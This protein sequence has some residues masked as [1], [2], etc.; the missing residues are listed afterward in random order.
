[1]SANKNIFISYIQRH[2]VLYNWWILLRNLTNHFDSII[3]Y[4]VLVNKMGLVLDKP[5]SQELNQVLWLALQNRVKKAHGSLDIGVFTTANVDKEMDLILLPFPDVI[6]SIQYFFIVRSTT[7]GAEQEIKAIDM[8]LHRFILFFSKI[9]KKNEGNRSPIYQLSQREKTCLF[10]V[11]QG[12]SSWETSKIVGIT[13]RT[14]NLHITN[15]IRKTQSVNRQQAIT[16][17]LILNE[18]I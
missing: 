11:A 2:E 18:I 14:V 5:S 9:L 7:D 15:A 8:S 1:M 17:C 16:K 3:N 10:W 6:S 12:K 13:E 4:G